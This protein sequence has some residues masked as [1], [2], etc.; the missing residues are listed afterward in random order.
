MK[1]NAAFTSRLNTADNVQ[2]N[3]DQNDKCTSTKTEH[4]FVEV[5]TT[6]TKATFTKTKKGE[7]TGGVTGDKSKAKTGRNFVEITLER[8]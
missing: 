5:L 8:P 2:M 4:T 3:T 1:G 7:K 6:V